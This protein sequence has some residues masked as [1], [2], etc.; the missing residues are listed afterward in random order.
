MASSEMA[1]SEMLLRGW[2]LRGWLPEDSVR[3][4]CV[5]D[6]PC[7]TFPL[8]SPLLHSIV[9]RSAQPTSCHRLL[10]SHAI[11]AFCRFFISDP[12]D[13]TALLDS[14]TNFLPPKE[15]RIRIVIRA[16]QAKPGKKRL[17]RR[18]LSSGQEGIAGGE[19]EG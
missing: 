1:S 9:S 4:I 8:F 6:N 7:A 18:R 14:Y 16:P 19:T 15:I 2:L 3:V 5:A 17:T 10:K 11:G 12:I 13:L